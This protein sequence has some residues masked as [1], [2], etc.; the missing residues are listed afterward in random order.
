MTFVV[1]QIMSNGIFK[2]PVHRVAANSD[3]RISVAM[4]YLLDP[5]KTL[6]PAEGLVGGE[7]GRLYRSMKGKDFANAFFEQ[8]TK[9]VYTLE[10][11]Q[12]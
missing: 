10:W 11:A 1:V 9:G 12:V 7:R 6:E 3:E 8:Y 4:L 2:S 5:E